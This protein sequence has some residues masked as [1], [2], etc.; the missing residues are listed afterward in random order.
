LADLAAQAP[1]NLDLP[2]KV[3]RPPDSRLNVPVA[4]VKAKVILFTRVTVNA[5]FSTQCFTSAH[6]EG[7]GRNC[8]FVSGTTEPFV[9]TFEAKRF[10]PPFHVS[11]G[12]RSNSGLFA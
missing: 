8:Y 11:V 3:P 2:R 5:S 7:I 4:E 6:E 1:D 12:L 10:G 9:L